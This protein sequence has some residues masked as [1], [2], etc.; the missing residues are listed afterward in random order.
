M[1]K[2]EVP[3]YGYVRH[4]QEIEA[5]S[6]EEAIK[7][8]YKVVDDVNVDEKIYTDFHFDTSVDMVEEIM[9]EEIA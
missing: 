6:P 4:I 8:A 7:K 5:N 2:Y 3:M 1:K 9:V